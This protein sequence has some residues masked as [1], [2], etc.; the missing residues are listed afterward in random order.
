MPAASYL[1]ADDVDVRRRLID[2]IHD[3]C[4]W[5]SDPARSAQDGPNVM[6]QAIFWS[7]L[8]ILDVATLGSV[9]KQLQEDH[10]NEVDITERSTTYMAT[11]AGRMAR[12]CRFHTTR[13]VW[14]IITKLCP[15][16][17][18]PQEDKESK[19][20]RSAVEADKVSIH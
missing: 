14:P 9:L 19:Y 12:I 11:N 20:T 6:K 5:A 3:E 13:P 10:E 1:P 17:A 18:T 2:Q 15:V 8:Q 4:V 16:L 7:V